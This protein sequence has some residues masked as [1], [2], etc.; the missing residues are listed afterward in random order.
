M[1]SH[2]IVRRRRAVSYLFAA[3][4]CFAP[5]AAAQE[6]A[7]LPTV[8]VTATPSRDGPSLTAPTPEVAKRR[9]KQ[10]PGGASIV[11][12]ES[13]REGRVSTLEDTFKYTPGVLA[14]PRFGAEETRLSIRG[15]GIQRTFH[16][17]GVLLLQDGTPL[18]LADGSGDFQ[19]IEPLSA[20]YIEVWRGANALRYGAATLG[21]AINYESYTGYTASPLLLRGEGGS[22]GYWRSQVASGQAFQSADYY[23]S[24]STFS[25]EGFRRHAEQEGQR[26][27]ANGGFRLSDDIETRFYVT[28]TRGNSEL[29]GNLTKAQLN[30]DPR[31]ANPVNVITDQR[32]DVD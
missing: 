30:T 18:N 27:Y 26:L 15:S 16:L 21:G 8:H 22:F 12:S 17:R 9:I 19:T 5:F 13:Y 32:R 23:A 4:A 31:Q 1:E 29:P 20:R 11:D 3:A 10:T 25:Q 2:Q 24:V 28:A 14:Q 6:P 7:E